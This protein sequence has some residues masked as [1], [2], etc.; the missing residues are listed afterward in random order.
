VTKS[1][2]DDDKSP[3]TPVYFAGIM[4][5]KRTTFATYTRMKRK[6]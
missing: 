2:T 6:E 1:N 5:Y 3:S 4:K